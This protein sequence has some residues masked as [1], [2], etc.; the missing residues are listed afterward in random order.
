MGLHNPV[1][2]GRGEYLLTPVGRGGEIL[3]PPVRD[4]TWELREI[5]WLKVTQLIGS[6]AG[7]QT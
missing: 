7:I 6:R 3:T 2:P 4:E 1:I 5:Q